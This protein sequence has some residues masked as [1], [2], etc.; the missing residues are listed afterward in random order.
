M[1]VR[2]MIHWHQLPEDT[3]CGD[4]EHPV[5]EEHVDE[6]VVEVDGQYTLYG[7]R[8]HVHHV[9][10][11]DLKTQSPFSEITENNKTCSCCRTN[12]KASIR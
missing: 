7:V 1:T 2:D 3:G 10:T 12:K 5:P 9:L 6:L 8:L 4:E 11:S